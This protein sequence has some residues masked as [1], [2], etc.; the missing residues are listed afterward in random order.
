MSLRLALCFLVASA[1]PVLAQGPPPGYYDT[2]DESSP[3]ALRAT[4]HDVIDDHQRFPYT[5]GATDTWDILNQAM[6]D[7]NNASRIL[8]VYRNESFPKIN[9]GSRDYNREHTW[10]KS[11]GFPND[12]SFNYP[13]SDCHMLWLC[14]AGYNS[15]R[16]NKPFRTC[17][18]GCFENVTLNN[19][20]QGGG[21]G[22]YPGNSNWTT[23][24]FTSGTWEV[25]IGRRGDIARAQFYA[26]LRYGGG[27]HGV[28]FANEPDLILTD[29]ES[30]IAASNTGS[31]E[32]VAHH[33]ML[34]V[35]LQWHLE[36]PVDA[37]EVNRN[38]VVYNFQGNRNPFVD[39]PEWADCL[40]NGVCGGVPMPETYCTGKINSQFCLATV[41]FDGTPSET[42]VDPF[43]VTADMV[44]N[45]KPGL[46]FYGFGQTASPFLGGTLCVQ[47]PLRRT[48]VQFSAGN[49]PPDDCSGAYT[50]DFNALIQ[51]GTDPFLTQGTEVFA[52]YWYRDPN[53]L[54]ATGSGLSDAVKFTIAP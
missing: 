24:A 33:G 5:S 2:V 10:P 52:Q 50:F 8:D 54:F 34:S 49:P 11:Y 12:N 6:E 4:L 1:A 37:W 53:D 28:T 40:F 25:W 9:G 45:N 23:G 15:T 29:N 3:A 48:A 13:Y 20:G 30:L 14:D 16:S 38:D 51:A 22:V 46:L 18:P 31:N 44:I 32:S 27:Q 21:S 47:P 7:P 26:D 19:N 35:L 39:H 43:D 41:D 42:D 36:D 17:S